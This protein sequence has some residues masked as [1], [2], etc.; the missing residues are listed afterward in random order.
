MTTSHVVWPEMNTKWGKKDRW[1]KRKKK[2]KFQKRDTIN[3][4][5]SQK[6]FLKQEVTE[7]EK[8][9]LGARMEVGKK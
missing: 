1:E 4:V 2:G 3:A 8:R 5:K 7:E 9:W 6:E